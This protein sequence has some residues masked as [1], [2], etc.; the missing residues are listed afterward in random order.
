MMKLIFALL[1]VFVLGWMSLCRHLSQ[2]FQCHEEL[3]NL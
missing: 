2:G 3:D 1:I